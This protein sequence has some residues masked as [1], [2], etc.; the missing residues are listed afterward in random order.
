[1]A[2]LHLPDGAVYRT[3]EDGKGYGRELAKWDG[4]SVAG[5]VVKSVDERRYTLSV[6]YPADT[7][8]A[9]VA[10]DG[11]LDFAS[12]AEVEK[13]AWGYMQNPGVGVVHEDGT[14]GA[15]QI[16]ESYIYRGPDWEIEATDG[17]KQVIKSGD[18]LIGTVWN[19]PTW[20]RIKARELRGTSMQGTAARR[21]PSPADVAKVAH[22][23]G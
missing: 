5:Q 16:V 4:Q 8:D 12:A 21:A 17:S 11:H 14:E 22:R 20:E 3:N 1:M 19:E 7:P 2:E 13:A 6:G 9:A 15:G 23:R 18:W 10:R